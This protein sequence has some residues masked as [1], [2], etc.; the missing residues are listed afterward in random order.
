VTFA[1]KSTKDCLLSKTKDQPIPTAANPALPRAGFFF[2][3]RSFFLER[4]D[5]GNIDNIDIPSLLRKE[6]WPE[7]SDMAGVVTPRL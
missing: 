6:G 4:D 2:L 5:I 3:E 7:R 1:A